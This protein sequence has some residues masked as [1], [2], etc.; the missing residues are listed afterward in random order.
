MMRILPLLLTLAV[1]PAV[2]QA[3]SK[4]NTRQGFWIGFGFGPGSTGVDCTQCDDSRA[5]GFT[6]YLRLGG[7]LSPKLLLGGESNGWVNIA[8]GVDEDMEF[9][10]VVLLWYPKSEGAW[11]L[12]FG[13]GGMTFTS[14]DS[15]TGDKIEADAPSFSLGGGYEIRTGRNFSIVPFM[16]ILLTAPASFKLNGIPA[17]GNEDISMNLVQIGAGVTWH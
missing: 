16:N 13:L 8:S 5:N 11:Y 15:V 6:G 9:A 12:K 2:A 3:Q 1:L 14:T 17:G 7:T 4:P 10:S